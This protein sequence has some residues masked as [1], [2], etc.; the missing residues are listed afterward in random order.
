MNG[1]KVS[2]LATIGK[3]FHFLITLVFTAVLIFLAFVWSLGQ[4]VEFTQFM[5]PGEER[6][7]TMLGIVVQL[8]PQVF[9]ALAS[10]ATGNHRVGWLAAFWAFSAFDAATNV[11]ARMD[12]IVISDAR[13]ALATGLG[14]F[15]DIVIVFA[16]EM[17]AYSLSILIDDFAQIWK[18]VGDEHTR[19]P[20]WMLVSSNIAHRLGTGTRKDR[21][22]TN[23]KD[24][25]VQRPPHV[26][27]F[28]NAS[29]L[30]MG[31]PKRESKRR[32]R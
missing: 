32:G 26:P 23:Q 18:D 9:L 16:E 2:G 8:G 10:Y 12:D 3:V 7:G 29:Q 17:I 24:N 5:F 27:D 19:I 20:D 31:Q 14:L 11:G 21:G 15:L 4:T 13:V 1:N 22:A 30:P 6:W 28:M 25:G